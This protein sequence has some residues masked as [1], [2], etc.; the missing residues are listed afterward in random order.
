MKISKYIKI[1]QKIEK[2]Y[3]PDTQ[4]CQK[5]FAICSVEFPVRVSVEKVKIHGRRGAYD[6]AVNVAIVESGR[7]VEYLENPDS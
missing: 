2:K 4:V 7:Y 3:G 6:E 1:L 5:N